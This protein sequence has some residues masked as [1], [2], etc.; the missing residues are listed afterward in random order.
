VPNST[1]GTSTVPV[2]LPWSGSDDVVGSGIV[3]YELERSI[4]G[5]AYS[6]VSLPSATATSIPLHLAPNTTYRFRV[7]AKAGAGNVGGW[8][9]GPSFYPKLH[10]ETTS[11]N[12]A[13]AGTWTNLTLT[14]ASGGQVRY[15]TAAGAEA[16]FKFTG[17]DVVWV[18]PKNT[19]RGRAEVWVDG[20]KA[21]TVDQYASSHQPRR[22][23][24]RKGW[25]ST[26]THT[27]E[28]RVLGTK[29][30]AS[31]GTR[32]DADAFVNVFD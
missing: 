10:Q 15:A 20:A 13:Y 8:V 17:K 26:G 4:N 22:V 6:T 19:N 3:G 11:G 28:V 14:G 16:T 30:A 1:L 2:A 5:G 27:V 12:I 24:F 25:A 18:A 9:E 29:Q 7:R 21:A 23:V 31:T 32:V